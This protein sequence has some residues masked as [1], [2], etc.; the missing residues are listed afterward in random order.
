MAVTIPKAAHGAVDPSIRTAN[1]P[2]SVP[3]DTHG[4]GDVA[5]PG[6]AGPVEASRA[7][8]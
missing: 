5:A 4:G 6:P 8:S 7:R 3:D 1:V 2:F